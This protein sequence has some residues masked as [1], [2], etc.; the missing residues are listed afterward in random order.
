[1]RD[2][3]RHLICIDG[4]CFDNV[5]DATKFVIY[6]ASRRRPITITRQED[7]SACLYL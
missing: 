3:V 6:L 1:M 2:C 4:L 7:T 5:P